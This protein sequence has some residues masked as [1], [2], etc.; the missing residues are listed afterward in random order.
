MKNGD[1]LFGKIPPLSELTMRRLV[2]GVW[3]HA[4]YAVK[5]GMMYSTARLRPEFQQKVIRSQFSLEPKALDQLRSFDEMKPSAWFGL[6]KIG[7]RLVQTFKPKVVVELGTHVGLSALAM[8]LALQELGQN[9]QIYAVDTWQ[10]DEHTGTYGGSIYDTFLQR[11]DT[12]GLADTVVPLRMLFDD[13]FDKIPQPIDLLHIDGLHTWEAVSHD[14]EKF[15][16]LV[17]PG[18]IVMFHDVNSNWVDVKRFWKTLKVRFDHYTVLQ[19]NGLGI[20]QIPSAGPIR[21]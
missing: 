12:L 18:G 3:R 21:S 7:Y 14:W 15:S 13:A 19:S 9:G 2:S 11:R 5:D 8:G 4:N 16:P 20:L 17:R 6:A 10:G 1:R